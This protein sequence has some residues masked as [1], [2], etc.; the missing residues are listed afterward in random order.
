MEK[1]LKSI[2]KEL[3]ESTAKTYENSYKRLRVVL[4]IKDKRRPIKNMSL[5]KIVEQLEGV[6]N[7]NTKYSMF[8]VVKKLFTSDSDKD[9]INELDQKIRGEKRDHQIKKNGTLKKELPTYKE[10][11]DAVK[12]ETKP[13]KYLINFIFLKVNTRN[14]DVAYIDLHKS[15]ENEDDLD[16]DR[17]HIY[18]K[19]NKAIFIRNKYKTFRSYGQKRNVINVKKFVDTVK[20]LLGDKDKV[21]LFE[22]KKGGAITV[23]SI[24]SYF[25][26]YMLLGLKEG[27]IMKIVLK[28]IDESGSYDSMRRVAANR[29][30]SIGTLLKEY[31]ISN[32][33]NPTNVITQNQ[34]VK[35][36]VSIE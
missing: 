3:K 1:E 30:T 17:N 9:K 18:I 31:D 29:G 10:L 27:E 8:V 35:Q 6:E 5:D 19:D 28:H 15:V 34:D 7:P 22:T 2:T 11:S 20:N 33:K 4:D 32:V 25:K 23:G 12:K 14:M 36:E 26:R 16:K 24:G 13:L 21:A